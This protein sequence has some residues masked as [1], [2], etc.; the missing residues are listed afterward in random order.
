MVWRTA[1]TSLPSTWMPGMPAA[2]AFCAS[3]FDA[4][5]SASGTLM[6]HLLLTTTNTT[7]RSRTAARFSAS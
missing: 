2:T 6:A 1:M 7:G 3:V 5:C 4:V